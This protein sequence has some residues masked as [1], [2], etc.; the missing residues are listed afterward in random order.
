[1]TIITTFV[2]ATIIIHILFER[3]N[4]SYSLL[5]SSF[6][7]LPLSKTSIDINIVGIFLHYSSS[8]IPLGFT[9]SFENFP[10]CMAPYPNLL[11]IYYLTVSSN[12]N[13]IFPTSHNSKYFSLL[14]YASLLCTDVEGFWVLLL[15][16]H[17]TLMNLSN[18][19]N[20]I[21]KV[22]D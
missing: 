19:L 17:C 11:Q 4:K 13:T 1:M 5:I 8:S 20:K 3:F 21:Y 9:Q 15:S 12:I 6:F 16:V 7:N 10:E 14:L 18:S 22:I 2:V